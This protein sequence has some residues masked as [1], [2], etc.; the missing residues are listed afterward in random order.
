M[1]DNTPKTAPEPEED[2]VSADGALTARQQS[3]I[4]VLLLCPTIRGAS[5]KSG[6][7]E[8][9]LY[10]WLRS[11]LFQEAYREA[12]EASLQQAI[13]TLQSATG[14]A[15]SVMLSL[16]ANTKTAASVR[17]ASAR[18]VLEY[19]FKAKEMQ[20]IEERLQALEEALTAS[21]ERKRGV[22]H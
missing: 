9:S 11:P 21:A 17:L 2:E 13:S 14:A 22:R 15:V 5:E 8:S 20:E 3:A 7:P 6:V 10:R 4:A 18:S 16:M 1:K 12:R 19:A